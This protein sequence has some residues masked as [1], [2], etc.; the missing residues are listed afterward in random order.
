[1]KVYIKNADH[2]SYHDFFYNDDSNSVEK[3]QQEYEEKVYPSWDTE[4]QSF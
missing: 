1:M 3:D 4:S 2:V